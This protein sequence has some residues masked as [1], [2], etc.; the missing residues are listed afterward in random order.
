MS[1]FSHKF[2]A[3][4]TS[5]YC[6]PNQPRVNSSRSRYPVH[7]PSSLADTT[8][9][10]SVNKGRGP[11]YHAPRVR[12]GDCRSSRTERKHSRGYLAEQLKWKY[13]Y[14]PG[15]EVKPW[16]IHEVLFPKTLSG[17]IPKSISPTENLFSRIKRIIRW[18]FFG[19]VF[20]DGKTADSRYLSFVSAKSAIPQ[21]H[22]IIK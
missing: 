19:A 20:R 12:G 15:K 3:E 11:D 9:M 13:S 10:Y 17:K 2:S 22:S 7:I 5:A 14:K 1:V 6:H 8:L 4:E 16:I 21:T 18:I